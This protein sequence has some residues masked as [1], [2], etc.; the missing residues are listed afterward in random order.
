MAANVQ[1]AKPKA[2]S[3]VLT[4]TRSDSGH[5]GTKQKIYNQFLRLRPAAD[6]QLAGM[7]RHQQLRVLSTQRYVRSIQAKCAFVCVLVTGDDAMQFI[8]WRR[9]F[10]SCPRQWCH[11]SQHSQYHKGVKDGMEGEKV[12]VQR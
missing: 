2:A 11:N 3:Q 7:A 10:T 8:A 5:D 12:G 4:S 1:C 9:N 6:P